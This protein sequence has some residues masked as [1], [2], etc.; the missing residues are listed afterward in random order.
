MDRFIVAKSTKKKLKKST[1]KSNMDRFIVENI[2]IPF[3]LQMPLKSNMDR[4]IVVAKFVI[5]H[6]LFFKIQYG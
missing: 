6:A 5:I 4:F 1:L 3:V 2:Q